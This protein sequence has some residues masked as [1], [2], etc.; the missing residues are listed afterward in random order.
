[1]RQSAQANVVEM[2]L[3]RSPTSP[4]KLPQWEGQIVVQLPQ[5]GAP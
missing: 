2:R 5:R 1:V 4:D 3:Q